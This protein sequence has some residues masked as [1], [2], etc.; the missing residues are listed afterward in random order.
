MWLSSDVRAQRERE[1]KIASITGERVIGQHS[2]RAAGKG[3]GGGSSG[4]RGLRF[5]PC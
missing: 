2:V 5:S 4:V 1:G 3:G